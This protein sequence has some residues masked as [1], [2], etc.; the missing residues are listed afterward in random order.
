MIKRFLL[1]ALCVV[2]VAAF[3]ERPPEELYKKTC[4]VCHDSG[5]IPGALKVG[6]VEGWQALIGEKGMEQLVQSVTQ[7]K[8]AMPP[9]GMCFDCTP[10]EYEALVRY[11]ASPRE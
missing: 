3:A 6:D 2:S 8:N 7:G 1:S 10:G 11:M 4:M 5:R 9:R